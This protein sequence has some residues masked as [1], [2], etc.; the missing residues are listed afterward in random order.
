MGVSKN[1]GTPKSSIG[2]SIIN[3]PFWGFS[4]Y[5]W[6]DPYIVEARGTYHIYC[7]Q[8]VTSPCYMTSCLMPPPHRADQGKGH[9]VFQFS[10]VLVDRHAIPDLSEPP[11]APPG[12]IGITKP[13]ALRLREPKWFHAMASSDTCTCRADLKTKGEVTQ[14]HKFSWIFPEICETFWLWDLQIFDGSTKSME[15][16]K[17]SDDKSIQIHPIGSAFAHVPWICSYSAPTWIVR[18]LT[19]CPWKLMVGRRKFLSKLVPFQGTDGDML[20]FLG[21]G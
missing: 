17:R 9:V 20:I 2:F 6:K 3:H 8:P 18:K 4:P 10:A 14:N 21:G 1:R 19:V 11:P 7:D 13:F 12:G 5:F 15:K 16:K